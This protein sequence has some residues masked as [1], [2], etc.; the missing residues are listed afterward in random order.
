MITSPYHQPYQESNWSP[1][2]LPTLQETFMRIGILYSS[3]QRHNE[4]AGDPPAHLHIQ[5]TLDDLKYDTV[6]IDGDSHQ[7]IQRLSMDALSVLVIAAQGQFFEDGQ[8]QGLCDWLQ[9]PYVGSGRCASTI[10]YH[11]ALLDLVHYGCHATYSEHMLLKPQDD[12]PDYQQ[13]TE[14]LRSKTLDLV[15]ISSPDPLGNKTNIKNA[16]QFH[17]YLSQHLDGQ[18]AVMVQPH[19]TYLNQYQVVV[20]DLRLDPT[21]MT[22]YNASSTLRESVTPLTLANGLSQAELSLIEQTV[23]QYYRQLLLEGAALFH[24]ALSPH[25]RCQVLQ[26]RTLP[27]LHPDGVLAASFAEE[28]TSY[29]QTLMSLINR[30]MH[31]PMPVVN[32]D[33]M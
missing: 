12:T 27:S 32:A 18:R 2:W 6:L 5:R 3:R 19:R 23:V 22:L 8:L 30:A 4:S 33:P 14:Y 15:P 25:H 10:C 9:L 21:A 29:S 26:I 24:V 13:L 16:R 17:R 7:L 28:D 20:H 11:P 31:R 1:A